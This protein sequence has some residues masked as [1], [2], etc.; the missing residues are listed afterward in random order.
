MDVL[1]LNGD[2]S[3]NVVILKVVNMP[4]GFRCCCGAEETVRKSLERGVN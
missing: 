3:L 2:D 1:T 4:T